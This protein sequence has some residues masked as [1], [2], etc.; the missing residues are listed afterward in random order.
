MMDWEKRW[1]QDE[2]K[3][4][5]IF[6]ELSLQDSEAFCPSSSLNQTYFFDRILNHCKGDE[7]AQ[8]RHYLP[9]NRE[10]SRFLKKKK[11]QESLGQEKKLV[12]TFFS[13]FFSWKKKKR[14]KILPHFCSGH[15][16]GE[17]VSPSITDPP[18]WPMWKV[19]FFNESSLR[20]NSLCKKG[21]NKVRFFKKQLIQNF[22][23]IVF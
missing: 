5:R 16:W 1:D 6:I 15:W 23:K 7:S 3:K 11:V 12:K 13:E 22:S 8:T 19:H 10:V 14:T 17:G 2:E 4:V 20:R 21:A 18:L 9:G